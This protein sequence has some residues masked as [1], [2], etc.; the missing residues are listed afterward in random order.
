MLSPAVPCNVF[1]LSD[2]LRHS[3]QEQ[4]RRLSL[5]LSQSRGYFAAKRNDLQ[6]LIKILKLLDKFHPF[7]LPTLS[8]CCFSHAS[9]IKFDVVISDVFQGSNL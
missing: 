4:D 9:Q 5:K 8:Q 1:Y 3:L 2:C 6:C 7:P